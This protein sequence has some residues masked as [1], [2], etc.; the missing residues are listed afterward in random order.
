MKKLFLILLIAPL[1]WSCEKVEFPTYPKLSGQWK[2]VDASITLQGINGDSVVY[3]LNDTIITE[4]Y[5]VSSINGNVVT[6][7]QNYDR[8]KPLDRFVI[9]KTIWE[10]ETNI[11]GLPS[12]INN[13]PGY[14][15]QTYYSPVQD[16]YSGNY[17]A[18]KTGEGRYIQI[19]TY[20]L[21]ELKLV[22]PNVWTMFRRNTSVEVFL[23]EN[24]VLHF[25][26]I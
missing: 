20:G 21:T 25:R 9:N 8:A 24:V 14:T 17:N 2:L 18:L 12:M 10:F 15:Y 4:Q 22:Y 19:N 1:L 16:L 13:M 23:K 26:R 6:F 7:K 11:L 3:I 5:N